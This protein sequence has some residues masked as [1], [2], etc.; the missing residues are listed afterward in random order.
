MLCPRALTE[1]QNLVATLTYNDPDKDEIP[2]G[3]LL[4]R[5]VRVKEV[6]AKHMILT[7]LSI[8]VTSR[9]VACATERCDG[10][11]ASP[12]AK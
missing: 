5:T 3:S 7:L 12:G 4:N 8:L 2:P 11:L 10:L 6:S 1:L 9:L